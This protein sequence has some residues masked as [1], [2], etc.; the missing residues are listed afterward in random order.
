M[1]SFPLDA[2]ESPAVG[3]VLLGDVVV[4]PTYA[5]RQAADHAGEAGHDG[6]LDDE[7]ALLIVHGVLHV[8]GHDHAAP[9]ETAT[10][11]AEEQRLLGL[12]HRAGRPA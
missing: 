9:D 10:M 7:L 5:D 1:L 6:T 12:H 8:L 3:E 4:C 2:G 11:K